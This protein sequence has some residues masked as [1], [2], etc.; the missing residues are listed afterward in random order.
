MNHILLGILLGLVAGGIAVGFMVPL[1]FP[2]KRAAL[3]AAFVSRFAIGFLT[4]N[5]SM[6][7][8]PTIAGLG[9]GLLISIPDALVTK[10]YVPI[11]VM[12]TILGGLCGGAVWL[13]G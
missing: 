2:D 7:V 13:W 4:S 9:I 10:A 1:T 5:T 3:S 11:L 12:G 6:P 8:N